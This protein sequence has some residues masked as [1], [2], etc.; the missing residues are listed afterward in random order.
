MLCYFD[1]VEFQS[2]SDSFRPKQEEKITSIHKDL[3]RKDNADVEMEKLDYCSKGIYFK[4]DWWE[5]QGLCI[6][7][8]IKAF[9]SPLICFACFVLHFCTVVSADPQFTQVFP[10]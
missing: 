10:C 6:N 9:L 5:T 2:V 8:E 1:S 3:Q 4:K 7:F